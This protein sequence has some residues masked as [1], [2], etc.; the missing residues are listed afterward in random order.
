MEDLRRKI[1]NAFRNF[2]SRGLLTPAFLPG[3]G[4]GE[5]PLV[6]LSEDEDNVYVQ[7]LLPGLESK[8]VEIN[9][10]K[11]ALTISGERKEPDPKG[12]TWHRRERGAGRFLRAIDIPAMVATDKASAEYRDGILMV[13]LPKAD[14]AKP[15]KIAVNFA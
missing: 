7:A 8:E 14:E 10:I 3:L 6:N 13:T 11:G 12:R 5:F 15:K 4:T 1:D 9:V 2:G